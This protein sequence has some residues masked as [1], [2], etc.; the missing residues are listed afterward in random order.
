[1]TLEKNV[2]RKIKALL[3][4][5]SPKVTFYRPVPSRYGGRSV[6]YI[7]CACGFAFYIE[8]KRPGRVMTPLQRQ[9]MLDQE[10]AGAATFLIDDLEL[11]TLQE[12]LEWCIEKHPGKAEWWPRAV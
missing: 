12:W 7:G 1:M 3:K 10:A 5:Y 2:T 6:D 4:S 8:A 11:E 9:F